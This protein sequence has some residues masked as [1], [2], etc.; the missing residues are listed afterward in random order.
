MKLNKLVLSAVLFLFILPVIAFSQVYSQKDIINQYDPFVITINDMLISTNDEDFRENNNY[1]IVITAILGNEKVIKFLSKDDFMVNSV[2]VGDD[3]SQ[4]SLTAK[5]NNSF[6]LPASFNIPNNAGSIYLKIEGFSNVNA[7]DVIALSQ[8]STSFCYVSSTLY[9]PMEQAYKYLSTNTDINRP[10]NT[11]LTSAEV[12]QQNMKTRPDVFYLGNPVEITYAIPQDPKKSVGTNIL[13]QGKRALESQIGTRL[14][15]VINIT[16]TKYTD[17]KIVQSE[18]Y[19]QKIKGVF[20]D[21]TSQTMIS[22]DK[23]PGFIAKAQ[24]IIS[25][26]LVVGLKSGVYL[27]D[28]VVRQYTN[29]MNLLKASVRVLSDSMQTTNDMMNSDEREA[30]SYFETNLRENDFGLENQYVFDDYISSSVNRGVLQKE[31]DSIRRYYQIK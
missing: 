1:I 11:L 24:D 17:V 8:L 23:A 3:I 16:F 4:I 7:M 22:P 10:N 18:P 20:Q 12:L 15:D 28:Q 9:G 14:K 2:K 27:N 19:Y 30:L 26:D 21:I 5:R 31:I 25:S 29:L 13:V 6:I